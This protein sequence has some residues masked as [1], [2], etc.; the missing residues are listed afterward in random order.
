MKIP[1]GSNDL[2][3]FFLR[4]L[5]PQV[6]LPDGNYEFIN[7]GHFFVTLF[8]WDH[9]IPVY[10]AYTLQPSQA[11]GLST[12]SRK[13]LGKM[14]KWRETPGL[15][16]IL[17]VTPIYKLYGYVPHFRVWF[18]FCFRGRSFGTIREW[19]YTEL[20]VIVFFWELFWFRK[21]QNSTPAIL[22]P[23]PE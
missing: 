5:E 15:C 2:P 11:A 8:D 7:Q 13:K 22:L 9:L 23:I 4:G 12:C 20:A 10:S 21:E 14:A 19:E 1:L 18:S 17:W 6:D 16:S 3:W